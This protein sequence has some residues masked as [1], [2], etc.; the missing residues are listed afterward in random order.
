MFVDIQQRR[1]AF[2]SLVRI[3]AVKTAQTRPLELAVETFNSQL[4]GLRL[5][6]FKKTPQMQIQ[7]I[8]VV[9][10]NKCIKGFSDKL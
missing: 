3:F 10:F 7:R 6:F 9:S 1:T 4:T 2:R 5:F 8:A